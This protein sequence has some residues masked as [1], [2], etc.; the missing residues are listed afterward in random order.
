MSQ[1]GFHAA[2]GDDVTNQ[3]DFSARIFWVSKMVVKSKW[4]L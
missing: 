4:I 2:L 1:P 3:I